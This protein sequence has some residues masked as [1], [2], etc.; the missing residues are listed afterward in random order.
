M[1]KSKLYVWTPKH[2]NLTL[3]ARIIL[4][5]QSIFIPSRQN[6]LKRVI[7]Q[8]QNMIKK[9]IATPENKTETKSFPAAP[10]TTVIVLFPGV[11][12][13]LGTTTPFPGVGVAVGTTLFPVGVGEGGLLDKL[14]VMN[15]TML[16]ETLLYG[17]LVMTGAQ[18]LMVIHCVE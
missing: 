7:P 11:V 17:Q 6:T 15:G 12:P 5:R 4:P 10:E 8:A 9:T 16:V 1:K 13:L 3:K 18:L 2:G 14:M